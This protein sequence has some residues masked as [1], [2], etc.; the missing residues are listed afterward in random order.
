MT[1]AAGAAE[2]AAAGATGGAGGGLFG[3]FSS[4]QLIETILV[5]GVANQV[6]QALLSPIFTKLQQEVDALAT[7]TPI[8]PPDLADL[9]L[10]GWVDTAKGAEQSRL[11]GVSPDDFDLLIKGTGEP[12]GLQ[13]VMEWYRRGIVPWSSDPGTASVEEAIRTSRIFTHVWSEAIRHGNVVPIPA[14]EAVDAKVEGQIGDGDRAAVADAA[15]G[16]TGHGFTP[17]ATTF[18]EI[19]WANGITPEQADVMFHTRGNPPSPMELIDLFR[20]GLIAWTGAGFDKTTVQQGI[21]E[22]A[23]KDKWEPIY[24]GL[25]RAIPSLYEV[26][27]MLSKG[28]FDQQTAL[29]YLIDSGYT[30][31]VA[32][33]VLAAATAVATATDR[34]LAKATITKLYFDQ[35]IPR[36]EAL[37]LLQAI[38]L[39]KQ[40]ATFTLSVVDLTRQ[41]KALDSAV[42]RIG[43]LYIARK[44][45]PEAAKS[46]LANYNLPPASASALVATWTVERESNVKILTEAQIVDGWEYGALTATEAF[47]E[48]QAIGYTPFDAWVLMSNKAK[49]PLQTIPKPAR[50]PAPSGNIT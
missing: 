49:G 36:D 23:T 47:G 39:G 32:E 18:Y 31:S 41:V 6:L 13:T 40:A 9:V 50:G 15:A 42:N 30:Q 19:M 35:G 33:G 11:S 4:G 45:S 3:G 22:G 14:A 8:S 34:K 38:G 25:V 16:G 43:S 12:P 2:G 29:G 20:R 10:R 5:W 1:T 28:A 48:L 26:R 37:T 27:L 46:A 24:K 7:P 44:L 17:A 21:Y